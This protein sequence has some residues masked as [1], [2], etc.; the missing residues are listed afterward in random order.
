[1]QFLLPEVAQFRES[2]AR[3]GRSA[4]M[5]RAYR[6][7]WTHDAARCA[8]AGL[9]PGPAAP[10]TIR[11]YLASLTE[12][13]A[14]STR[15][16]LAAIGRMHPFDDLPW[17]SSDA[18]IQR[19]LRRGGNPLRRAAL[20]GCRAGDLV[21]RAG[22][23]SCVSHPMPTA[24]RGETTRRCHARTCPKPALL[25]LVLLGRRCRGGRACGDRRRPAGLS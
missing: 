10:E 12:T 20:V 9:M 21:E 17:E 13:H 24:E 25:W 14:P 15:R 18:G 11:A 16:R 3:P 6:K 22:G 19:T 7:A 2:G 23:G 5:L 8:A 4:A 1:M